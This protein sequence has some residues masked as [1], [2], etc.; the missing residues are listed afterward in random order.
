M[1]IKQDVDSGVKHA[2]HKRVHLQRK[3]DRAAR[4]AGELETLCAACADSK[5]AL[6][7]RAYASWIEGTRQMEASRSGSWERAAAAFERA[8]EAYEELGREDGPDQSLFYEAMDEL[9]PRMRFCRYQ[10]ARQRKGRA[11]EPLPGSEAAKLARGGGA[12]QAGCHVSWRGNE[13]KVM[14]ARAS[15]HVASALDTLQDVAGKPTSSEADL[16][17]FSKA[18]AALNDAKRA[19]ADA[20]LALSSYNEAPDAVR[21]S[22]LTDLEKAVEGFLIERSIDRNMC[23]VLMHDRQFRNLLRR[24]VAG[25]LNAPDRVRSAQDLVRN[26]EMLQESYFELADLGGQMEGAGGEALVE[27]CR[28]QVLTVKGWR[29]YFLAHGFFASG[30]YAESF[31]LFERAMEH[32][33][34]RSNSMGDC[35]SGALGA[36]GMDAGSLAHLAESYKVVSHAKA[37]ACADSNERGEVKDQLEGL[38][39]APSAGA[40]AAPKKGTA[41]LMDHLGEFRSFAGGK[42]QP[43]RIFQLQPPLKEISHPPIFLDTVL[44]RLDYPDLAARVGR[45]M[46]KKAKAS[47]APLEGSDSPASVVGNVAAGAAKLFGWGR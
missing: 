42:G 16:Q 21:R 39:L 19:V 12:A 17:L 27:D 7:A 34:E 5:T 31:V 45:K 18:L 32:A 29:C 26:F 43:S 6:E 11:D 2:R 9:E 15:R 25:E 33:N 1:Q 47:E 4:A 44:E 24:T 46:K 35:G 3:L 20:L 37:L 41:F 30:K 28:A 36:A 14:D 38:G 22:A 8:R 13:Y 40:D 23:L 10:M